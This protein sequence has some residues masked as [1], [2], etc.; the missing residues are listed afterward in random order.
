M[1]LVSLPGLDRPVSALGFGC[2]SLGSRIAPEVGRAAI[3]R[4]LEAGVT[5]FDVA[6]S[7]GGGHAEH[8]LGAALAASGADVAIVTKVGLAPRPVGRVGQ[9]G[10]LLLRPLLAAAPSL[11]GLVRRLRPNAATRLPFTGNIVRTSLMQSLERLRVDHVAM[12]ALHE[13]TIE[14]VRNDGVIAALVDL[15]REGLI[16][17]I[18][19]AGSLDVYRSARAAGLPA[20][21]FQAANAPFERMTAALTRLLPSE[22]PETVVTHSVFGVDGALDM[23]KTAL[24]QPE[25]A[26][27]IEHLG[28]SATVEGRAR[29]LIDYAFAANP[30]GVVL[31]SA[32]APHHLAMNVAAAARAPQLHLVSAVDAILAEYGRVHRQVEERRTQIRAEAR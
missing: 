10:G 14:D 15:K 32:Y 31:T 12:L 19:I 5:W 29:L 1:R 22:T 21:V 26:R 20:T 11:R 13:P 6:P 16:A 24:R 23:L 28:Y 18:G 2:A 17:Q 3:E 30:R 4:A 27:H 9:L 7:Y 25:V 8:L